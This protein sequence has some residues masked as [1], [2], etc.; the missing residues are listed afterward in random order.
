[1]FFLHE[2]GGRQEEGQDSVSLAN[3]NLVP[4]SRINLLREE[5]R[6]LEKGGWAG[7]TRVAMSFAINLE[8]TVPRVFS[9]LP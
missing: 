3:S 1:M 6:D 7:A 2:G 4:Q 5:T 8:C 9:G